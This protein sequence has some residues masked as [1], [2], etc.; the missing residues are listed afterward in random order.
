MELVVLNFSHPITPEQQA[1]IERLDGKPVERVIEV[2]VEIDQRQ[3]FWPQI[4]ALASAT[5]LAPREWQTLK[6]IVNLPGLAVAA[7][8]LLV[9]LHGRMGYFPTILRL[10]PETSG[11]T[12]DY[13]VA[14][15]ENLRALRDEA[16]ARRWFTPGSPPVYPR[17]PT[18]AANGGSQRGPLPEET[19]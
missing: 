19:P 11:A 13:V 5:G 8:A 4:V 1:E 7:A 14:G 17:Q 12:T 18:G 10:R 3:P 9:E 15:L 6:L 16:R 2:P